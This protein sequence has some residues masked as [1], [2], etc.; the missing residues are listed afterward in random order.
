MTADLNPDIKVD[1][2]CGIRWIRDAFI[3]FT[4]GARPVG[5]VCGAG[6]NQ[7][8]IIKEAEGPQDHC[9]RNRDEVG[10]G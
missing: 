3:A 4:T 8:K 9:K 5:I 2:E 7:S 6:L 10:D 1:N